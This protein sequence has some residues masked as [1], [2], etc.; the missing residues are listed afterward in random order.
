MAENDGF[1][2]CDCA[3]HCKKRKKVSS[4]TWYNHAQY[5]DAVTRTFGAFEAAVAGISA[6]PNQP[7]PQARP[8]APRKQKKRRLN[9]RDEPHAMEVSGENEV[10]FMPICNRLLAN[11]PS[12]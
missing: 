3:R 8:L 4:A 7:Q 10:N 6:A 5:R 11:I 12:E 1:Y 9:R 2:Y